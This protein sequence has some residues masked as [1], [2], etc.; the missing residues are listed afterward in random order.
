MSTCCHS[1]VIFKAV[2]MVIKN[3]NGK[4]IVIREPYNLVATRFTCSRKTSKQFWCLDFCMNI[5][6]F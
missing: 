3:M 2:Q 4:D 1:C 6:N 5:S